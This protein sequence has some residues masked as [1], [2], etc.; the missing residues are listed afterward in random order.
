M[1]MF[2]S[3]SQIYIIFWV[4]SYDEWDSQ[5][6]LYINASAIVHVEFFA[7]EKK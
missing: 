7:K 2:C 3:D 1:V 4:V 6:K 5:N